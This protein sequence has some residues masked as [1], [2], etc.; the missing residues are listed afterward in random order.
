M[1]EIVTGAALLSVYIASFV[2]IALAKGAAP[3]PSRRPRPRRLR[4]R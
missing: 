1:V 2:N 3:P 4:P